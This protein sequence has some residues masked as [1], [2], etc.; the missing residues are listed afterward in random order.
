MKF[1]F[2]VTN[3]MFFCCSEECRHFMHELKVLGT[4][5]SFV[6]FPI[7]IFP[8]F[9]S[10]DTGNYEIVRPG[11]VSRE[12]PVPDHIEKPSY[13]QFVEEP[14]LFTSARPEIKML[15]GVEAMRK[16]CRLAANILDKCSEILKVSK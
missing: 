3:G 9:N 8:L 2:V 15:S 11:R 12:R 16:S 14:D 13:F 4:N 5:F 1:L 7:G 10:T 6:H